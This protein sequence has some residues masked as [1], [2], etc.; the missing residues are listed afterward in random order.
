MSIINSS[1]AR[2]ASKFMALGL[3]SAACAFSAHAA[4][5]APAAATATPTP[6]AQATT[7]AK[8]SKL[9]GGEK[10]EVKGGPALG[11][12][13]GN[14]YPGTTPGPIPKPHKEALK[15]AALKAK[16]KAAQ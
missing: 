11:Q 3:L 2:I 9:P 16:A 1:L 6:A 4:D 12:G 5:V 7:H 8:Q 15:A 10:L 14:Q 13:G